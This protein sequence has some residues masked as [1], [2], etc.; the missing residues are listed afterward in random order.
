MKHLLIAIICL[1]SAN[2]MAARNKFASAHS[3]ALDGII[4]DG[5]MLT[6]SPSTWGLKGQIKEQLMYTIGQL[7]GLDGGSPDMNRLEIKV[8]GINPSSIEGL[9][10]VTYDAKLFIA[11]P[12]ERRFPR[13]YNLL[14]PA[15]GSWAGLKAFFETYGADENSGKKCLAWE[16]HDVTQN[17]FW[18]YYRPE[19]YSCPLKRFMSVD[20]KVAMQQ[21]IF[22]S[23]S[24]KNTKGKYP[25]YD[26]IWEDGKLVVT[27]IFGKNEEG[28]TSSYDAGVSAYKSTVNTLLKT[29]GVPSSINV[30]LSNGSFVNALENTEVLMTFNLPQG[31]LEIALYLIDGI[32]VAPYSF[33][34]SYNERTLTSDFISYSGHSGLGANIRALARMGEFAKDQYQIFLV[35]GCDTF[36][37]VDDALRSAHKAVNPEFGADKYIDVIT[38]AMPSYF[39]MNNRSNMA[40]INALVG[41]K[42]TYKQILAGFDKTQRAVVTGEEDNNFPTPFLD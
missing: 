13:S 16:A 31:E 40:V 11:W 25:E 38:N 2:S 15:Q 30:A 19:K 35:N 18:Y 36:A 6:T 21:Q 22:L 34:Q 29:Y 14:L 1:L 9:F 7:N 26:K 12:I 4:S 17:M 39:H 33:Q 32:R 27:A 3:V 8:K 37:Y 23:L 20:P 41:G 28:S 5:K 24:E 10:E 42:K